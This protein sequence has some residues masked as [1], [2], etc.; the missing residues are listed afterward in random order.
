MQKEKA[1]P[2][3]GWNRKSG[4]AWRMWK[5]L[6]QSG[7]RLLG[8]IRPKEL[9]NAMLRVCLTE[10]ILFERVKKHNPV[11]GSDDTDGAESNGCL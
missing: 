1:K 5:L 3:L 4:G 11:R 8:K 10:L 7:S 9:K 6:P 2:H